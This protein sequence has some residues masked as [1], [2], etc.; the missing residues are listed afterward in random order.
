MLK[1][2]EVYNKAQE[3]EEQNYKFRTFLKNRA[4]YDELDA[5]FLELH[6]ELFENHDCSDCANCCKTFGICF[7]GDEASKIAIFLNMTFDGFADEYLSETEP[8]DEGQ[9]K[10]KSKPCSFLDSD[11]QCKI[12]ACKP[13]VCNNFPFTNQPDRLASML[14]IIGHAEVCPVVFEIL[15]RLKAIYRFRNWR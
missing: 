9:Y 10:F 12:N 7:S 3:L 6:N 13:N 14:S 4:D 2:N 8:S 1:P 15:E 11:G 5:H